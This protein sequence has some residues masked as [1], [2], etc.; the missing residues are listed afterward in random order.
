METK[1]IR[2]I[3]LSFLLIVLS[4]FT[5]T[6]NGFSQESDLQTK[7]LQDRDKAMKYAY[8]N[9]NG[10]GIKLDYKKAYYIFRTL[11][12]DGDAEANNAVGMMFKQGI[13]LKQMDEQALIYFQKAAEGGYAKA[14]LNIALMYKYGHGVKQDYS[15]FI[16]WLEKA[17]EMGY[18]KAEYLLGY[19]FYK[20]QGKKQDY[21]TAFQYFEKGA[22][23]G[24]ATCIYMLSLCYYHGRGVERDTDKGKYWMEIAADKGLSRAVDIIAR[25]DSKRYGEKKPGLR[26]SLNSDIN[27]LIPV[28]YSPVANDKNRVGRMSGKWEGKLVRYDWSGEEIEK[29]AK[30]TLTINHAGSPIEGLWVEDDTLSVRINATLNDSVWV[31]DNVTLYENQRPLDMKEGRFRIA[32]KNGKEYLM[33]NVS[34]YSETTRE[35]TAP[36]YLVLERKSPTNLNLLL[37]DN[38]ITVSPNPFNEQITVRIDLEQPQ[39]IRIVIYDLSGKRIET[40]ELLDYNAGTHVVNISTGAYPKGSYILK[41]AGENVNRSFT[42]IK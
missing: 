15:K 25:N 19:S 13:G 12:E 35:Y 8:R 9:L 36:H 40:G 16:E 39:K 28:K 2:K 37:K 27:N 6:F 38:Q 11:A 7:I 41:V 29:E 21:R 42:I 31:F 24:D 23:K 30:L 26:S 18:E 3:T 33:G 32:N 20:G 10:A 4:I 17:G 14:A 1:R 34:F 5:I 22:E